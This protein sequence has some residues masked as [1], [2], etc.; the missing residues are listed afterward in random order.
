VEWLLPVVLLLLLLLLLLLVLFLL[1]VFFFLFFPLHP[2]G[3][4][5]ANT[6]DVM[7]PTS[8]AVLERSGVEVA[9]ECRVFF[10][11]LL[12][13]LFLFL[14]F[15]EEVLRSD[16]VDGLGHKCKSLVRGRVDMYKGT[17][18]VCM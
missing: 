18:N 10:S 14:F 3:A 17:Y 12:F 16:A 2:G 6:C 9:T 4:M 11:S 5:S 13:L 15:C 7:F 1:L 8:R